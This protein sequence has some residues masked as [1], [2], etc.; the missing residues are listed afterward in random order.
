M[1]EKIVR[2]DY[3]QGTVHSRLV[4]CGL[5]FKLNLPATS[6]IKLN[7]HFAVRFVVVELRYD[8]FGS[9]P[10]TQSQ[11]SGPMFQPH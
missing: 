7:E 3:L 9:R 1:Q 4:F 2:L 5:D 6:L 10:I 8:N 11:T